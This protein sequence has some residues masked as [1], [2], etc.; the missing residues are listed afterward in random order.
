MLCRSRSDWNRRRE[1]PCSWGFCKVLEEGYWL[2][3]G[4]GNGRVVHVLGS[5]GR[6]LRL[7]VKVGK[8]AAL[9]SRGGA[10]NTKA[11]LIPDVCQEVHAVVDW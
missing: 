2:S 1:C 7:I 9:A 6:L 10:V 5:C 11:W 4:N 8:G 3:F